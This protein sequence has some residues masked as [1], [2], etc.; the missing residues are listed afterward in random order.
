MIKKFRFYLMC[1]YLD[2]FSR[3][4]KGENKEVK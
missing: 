2:D 1:M 3:P 4:R